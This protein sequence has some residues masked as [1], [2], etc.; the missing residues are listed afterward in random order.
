MFFLTCARFSP[1]PERLFSRSRLRGTHGARLYTR[2]KFGSRVC[3]VARALGDPSRKIWQAIAGSLSV[4]LEPRKTTE[5]KHF[6]FFALFLH[7]CCTATKP[8]YDT[9]SSF[10]RCYSH[11]HCLCGCGHANGCIWECM[12]VCVCVCWHLEKLP[13]VRFFFVGIDM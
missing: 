5:R 11:G 1:A 3:N 6:I 8:R 2:C 12:R 13:L 4:E 7:H 9:R 10:R